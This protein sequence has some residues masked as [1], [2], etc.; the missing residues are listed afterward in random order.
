LTLLDAKARCRALIAVLVLLAGAEAR[1]AR[2]DLLDE[3]DP[4]TAPTKAPTPPSKPGDSGAVKPTQ[5][6]TMPTTPTAP[7]PTKSPSATS[8]TDVG[9]G[10]ASGNSAGGSFLAPKNPNK[11]RPVGREKQPVKF[12]SRGLKGLREKGWV[13]L[14]SQVVVTQGNLR[15]EADKAQVFY[16]EAQ[17]DVLKVLAEGNVKISNV[18]ENTGE[19]LKAYGDQVVFHNKDRTVILEGNA[20]LWRGEDSVIRGKKIVYELDTGWIRADRVAGELSPSAG[21]SLPQKSAP[22]SGDKSDKGG[23]APP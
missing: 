6:P 23:G 9:G 15:M 8:G 13:E 2:A 16:D 20:R 7:K 1:P 11:P 17:K 14:E 10:G 19:K 5:P 18:D 4:A 3:E 22:K 12:E 21:D